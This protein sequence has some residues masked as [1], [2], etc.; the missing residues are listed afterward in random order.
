MSAPFL[1]FDLGNV[2]VHFDHDRACQALAELAKC[3]VLKVRSALFD[4][5]LQVRYET[6]VCNDETFCDE[7]R[8]RLN[9]DPSNDRL[10]H[11][12]SNIFE[13]NLPA[14]SIVFQLKVAGYRLGVLSNTCHAHWQW[15][16]QGPCRVLFG[17]FEHHVLSYEAGVMKPDP[18]IY[19]QA[20]ARAETSPTR[21][22]F[23]DDRQENVDA[24]RSAGMQAVLYRGV[25]PLMHQLMEFNA[26]V[27]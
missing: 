16:A 25:G 14:M 22:F 7:L 21:I 13:G 2:L 15:L 8:D 5:G 3:D 6:G 24:A 23:V 4:S 27:A 10:L 11:L 12:C 17:Y 26:R 20:I 9:I 1:F 19:E 18:E